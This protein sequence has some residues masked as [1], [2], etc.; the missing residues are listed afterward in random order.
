M[1]RRIGEIFPAAFFGFLFRKR[2]KFRGDTLVVCVIGKRHRKKFSPFSRAPH[3]L[4]DLRY[5]SLIFFF[6]ILF[7]ENAVTMIVETETAETFFRRWK[8]L[9]A[10]VQIMIVL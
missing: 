9:D 2:K 5:E 7:V 1:T 4:D 3:V 6:R 8:A 10:V